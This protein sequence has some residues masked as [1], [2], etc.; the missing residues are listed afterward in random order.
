MISG[1]MRIGGWNFGGLSLCVC[2]FLS[3]WLFWCPIKQVRMVPSKKGI[4][5]V[6]FGDEAQAGAALRGLN[7]FKLTP[8]HPIN[9]SYARK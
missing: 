6:E 7:D 8:E 4:A 5:F 1:M 3:W 2:T 9:L